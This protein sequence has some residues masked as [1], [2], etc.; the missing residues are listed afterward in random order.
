MTLYPVVVQE[1]TTG[2][3]LML[4]YANEE[5]LELTK[6]TGYAHF[7]SRERQKIWK[8]GETSGN[9]MRVVEIRRDCDDDAYLYIVDFPEDKVACHTGNRSCFFKVEHRFEETG[10]PT[11]WLDLY[12]LVKKRKEEMPEGSYTA[13]LF[14]EGKGKIAKKFGEEAVEVVTGYLQN[15]KENLVW[16][17]AD[18]IYHLTVLMADAGVTV[19]DVMK[20]L[21]KRRK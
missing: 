12:R 2:E 14:R 3:V 1:R 9:T 20:E 10:S 19:Q 11:F 8:K 13:K 18:M 16:E 6:K 15:D 21:E 4:A 5:A 17:I 7:F